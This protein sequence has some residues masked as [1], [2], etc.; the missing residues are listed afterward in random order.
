VDE[1]YFGV[2]EMI[3]SFGIVLGFLFW[4]LRSVNKAKKQRLERERAKEEGCFTF[5]LPRGWRSP[6]AFRRAAS[7]RAT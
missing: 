5:L 1:R 3:F 2:V 4:Q 7:E 6:R